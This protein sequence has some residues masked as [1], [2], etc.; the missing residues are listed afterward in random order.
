MP[1]RK[2]RD[3]ARARTTLQ[4]ETPRP[5]DQSTLIRMEEEAAAVIRKARGNPSSSG[6]I[7]SAFDVVSRSY[8]SHLMGRRSRGPKLPAGKA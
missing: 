8:Y 7:A 4:T 2:E 1:S 3:R 6:L 5:L